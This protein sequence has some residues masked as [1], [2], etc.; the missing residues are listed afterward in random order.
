MK[1]AK[2]LLC[3]VL[4]QALV[5]SVFAVSFASLSPQQVERVR[6]AVTKQPVYTP[7]R[8]DRNEPLEIPPLYDDPEVV[9]REQ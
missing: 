2:T 6:E 1:S 5:V 4:V 9:V 3:F 8:I 7:V